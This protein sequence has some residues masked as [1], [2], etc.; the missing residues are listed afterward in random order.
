MATVIRRLEQAGGVA[1]WGPV[2][3]ADEPRALL[4][5]VTALPLGAFPLNSS[6]PT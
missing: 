1:Q 6:V 2:D 4:A 5:R 3:V